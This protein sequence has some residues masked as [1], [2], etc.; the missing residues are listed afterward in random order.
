M[1]K[2]ILSLDQGTTNSKVSL[3]DDHGALLRESSR[4]L[5]IRYPRPGWVE[6]DAWDL[7]NSIQL[8]A[9]EV[10][11]GVQEKDLAAVAITNQRESTVLWDRR[12]GEPLGPCVTWQCHRSAPY[13]AELRQRGLEPTLYQ[14]TGLKIDPMFSAGK[15]RWLL[16]HI[17]NGKK[18]AENGEICFGTV[19][20]WIL[21]NLSGGKL[22]SCD[23]TNAS[24][25]QLFNL[26]TLAW[27]DEL[28]EIFGLPRPL[29][30]EVQPSS[31]VFGQTAPT[32]A[33]PA[34]IPI[35][36]LVGDSHGSLFGHRGFWPGAIKATYGTG[37]SLM[38]PI[39]ALA[40]S[41]RGLSTSIAFGMDRPENRVVYCLEGNIYATG[42]AVQWLAQLLGLEG[43]ERVEALARQVSDTGGVYFVPAL[44]GLGA[45]YWKEKA[46]GLVTGLTRGSSTAHLARASL[47][48]VAYQIRDV[49]EAMQV[50]AGVPL[51]HLLVD[52]GA[53][54]NEL[55]MQFQAD[56][57]NVPVY[58]SAVSDN[59]ALGAAYLA[60]LAVGIWDS[61]EEIIALPRP[62]QLFEP[63][64]NADQRQ[65]L[66]AG[67]KQAVE[68]TMFEPEE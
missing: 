35:G 59:S 63:Q 67:W 34:G 21:W 41:Q 4:P 40:F 16:D 5:E 12:S 45:P 26:H 10:L 49:F 42:A 65:Q 14:R 25:T 62:Q 50:E 66:Y 56:I 48:A 52:G 47:E 54:R 11:N 29:L 27:D 58:R 46:R 17:P 38:T 36:A 64:M 61:L 32:T 9:S 13:C 8:A 20:A 39:P 43:P 22:H 24:R 3:F 15:A 6:Q 30:P 19:D 1:T 68:R 2:T 23:V 53:T 7:W 44:V 31:F 33:I 60:G 55:L 51:T 57:L 18:R 37:S 28:L